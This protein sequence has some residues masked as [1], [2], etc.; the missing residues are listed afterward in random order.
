MEKLNYEQ[1]K[2]YFYEVGITFKDSIVESL[3]NRIEIMKKN[4]YDEAIEL[5]INKTIAT[6]D[7][8]NLKDQE[9]IRIVKDKWSMDENDIIGRLLF[10]RR[11]D[12]IECLKRYLK[13]QGYYE[14]EVK[15]FMSKNM[16]TVK[17]RH[18]KDL[19]KLRKNP[20]KLMKAVM[21]KTVK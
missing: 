19:W 13:L 2:H 4:V 11:T 16:A 7:D 3:Y 14:S 20:E 12:A 21:N 1:I 6:L 15:E 17:I 9:I 18:E 10:V 5:G 8:A